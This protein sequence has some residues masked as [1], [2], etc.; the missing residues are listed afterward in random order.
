[1]VDLIVSLLLFFF[2]VVLHLGV[3]RREK[4]NVLL[5]KTFLGM[6]AVGLVIF[7]GC[8]SVRPCA[9]TA[10]PVSA[11]MLY[12]LLVLVYL[13]FY[14]NVKVVSPSK[15]IMTLIRAHKTMTDEE[16]LTYFTDAEFVCSRLE[17]LV[18]SGCIYTEEERYRLSKSGARIGWMLEIYQ[19]ILGR[20]LGG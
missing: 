3:C 19:K 12:V 14:V 4:R 8:R 10:L 11:T 2:S 16:L 13:S 1:M 9:P 18:K 20:P 5:V 15:K 17:D 7:W 6:S